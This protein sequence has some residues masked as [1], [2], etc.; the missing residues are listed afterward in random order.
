[1]AP[2]GGDVPL[3]LGRKARKA[4]NEAFGEKDKAKATATLDGIGGK[5]TQKVKLLR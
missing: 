5:V 2:P 3:K 4:L 1:M